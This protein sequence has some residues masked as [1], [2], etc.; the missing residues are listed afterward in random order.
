[1]RVNPAGWDPFGQAVDEADGPAAFGVLPVMEAA[2]QRG[3]VEV[4]GAAVGPRVNVVGFAP[5]GWPVAGGEGAAAVAGGEGEA[6]RGAGEAPRAA[7]VEHGAA[8]V[9]D[10]GNE[11][12]V[13]G[14]L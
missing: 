12:G 2:Q 14:H 6:L 11:V 4:G 13:S 1:M 5:L 8:G 10:G 9:E 3:V 7:E